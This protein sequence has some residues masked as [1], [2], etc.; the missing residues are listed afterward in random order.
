MGLEAT[1]KQTKSIMNNQILDQAPSPLQETYLQAQTQCK[2]VELQ[3]LE[4]EVKER[5]LWL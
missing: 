5:L 2:I 1:K 4:L 3:T